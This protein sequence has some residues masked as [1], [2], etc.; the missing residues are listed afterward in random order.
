L[1]QKFIVWTKP[2][3]FHS[4]HDLNGFLEFLKIISFY[5]NL[6]GLFV[7]MVKQGFRPVGVFDG[8]GAILVGNAQN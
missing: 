7:G 5:S 3:F 8:S 6:I 2:R 4:I 1:V